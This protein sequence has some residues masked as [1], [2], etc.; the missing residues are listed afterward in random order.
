MQLEPR[1]WKRRRTSRWPTLWRAPCTR[2]ESETLIEIAA[3]MKDFRMDYITPA[4]KLCCRDARQTTR[5]HTAHTS[6]S[7]PSKTKSLAP[8][9]SEI[10]ATRRTGCGTGSRLVQVG[11][12]GRATGESVFKTMQS[13]LRLSP[14]L[15]RSWS[16]RSVISNNDLTRAR[17]SSIGIGISMKVQELGCFAVDRKEPPTTEALNP[18]AK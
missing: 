7:Q 17:S 14:P 10:G 8:Q 18:V 16:R 6:Q 11:L 3:L 15:F 1:S 2:R 12:H 4:L 9:H 5:T 13:L